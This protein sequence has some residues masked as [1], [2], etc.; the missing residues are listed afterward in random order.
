MLAPVTAEA[1]HKAI[2]ILG[3]EGI[4]EGEVQASIAS[5]AHDKMVARRLIAWIPEAF[6]IVLV[7]HLGKVNLPTTFSA[8]STD[9]EWKQFEF[10]LE[11]I[12]AEALRVASDMY[13][14]SDRSAFGNVAKRSSTVDVVNKVLNAGNSIEGAT[15]SGPALIGIPAEVYGPTPKS[16]W[17]R[18]LP[19]WRLA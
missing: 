14:S 3:V 9:G 16:M 6:G 19:G 18:L 8:R 5:F 1:I 11:P 7:T 4:P 12:F 13:H 17:R 15:L 10:K 2:A